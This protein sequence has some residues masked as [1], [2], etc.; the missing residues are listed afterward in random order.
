[1]EWYWYLTGISTVI[2]IQSVF[3]NIGLAKGWVKYHGKT[4]SKPKLHIYDQ[5]NS[6]GYKRVG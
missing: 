4:N 1:M 6:Q 5:D 3:L 2:F